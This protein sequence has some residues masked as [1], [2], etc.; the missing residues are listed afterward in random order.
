[1]RNMFLHWEKKKKEYKEKEIPFT[2]IEL[3][4]EQFIESF[5]RNYFQTKNNKLV[6][7]GWTKRIDHR[8]HAIDA[9]VIACTEPAHITRLNNLNKELQT[10]LD[11]HK[12]DLLPNFEGSPSELLDEILNLNE[13]EREKY[14]SKLTSSKL[15]TCLG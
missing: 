5:N 12:K 11:E 15:L 10:W 9:L 7:K 14:L 8:H 1:M 6:I 2:D 4:K 13:A 3:S